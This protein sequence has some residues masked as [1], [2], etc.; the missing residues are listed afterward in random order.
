[1]GDAA[2]Q[3]RKSDH[4]DGNAFDLTHDPT[5]GVD[6]NQLSRL[7]INDTRVTYVIWNRQIFNRARASEGWRPYTGANPHD[8]HM[9]VSISASARTTLSAWPWSSTGS[10]G[11]IPP[12]PPLSWLNGW[13]KVWDG[14]TYYYFFGPGGGVQYTKTPPANT[15]APPHLAANHGRYIYTPPNQ[16]VVMWNQV[17]GAE[18]ACRET[19]N[20][21]AI[22]CRQM[23]ATSNLYSPLF[24]TRLS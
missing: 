18:E 20:N 24:A 12:A 9:H 17:A 7:V 3:Q 4:N 1:M 11:P 19:F 14:N 15:T 22:G 23:N 2:H 10:L 5:H 13:W 8:H 21:A 16:L 6:C